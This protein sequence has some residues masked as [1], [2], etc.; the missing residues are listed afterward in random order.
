MSCG[1]ILVRGSILEFCISD[2]SVIIDLRC[3]GDYSKL[4]YC[5]KNGVLYDEYFSDKEKLRKSH[6]E[7]YF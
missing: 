6:I 7:E 4:N 5:T 3:S 1:Y 2:I